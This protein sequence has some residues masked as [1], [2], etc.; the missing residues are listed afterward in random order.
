MTRQVSPFYSAP[1]TFGPMGTHMH[2][3]WSQSCKCRGPLLTRTTLFYFHLL[4]AGLESRPV[5]FRQAFAQELPKMP[6]NAQPHYALSTILKLFCP[7]FHWLHLFMPSLC[8]AK[9]SGAASCSGRSEQSR[10]SALC[11]LCGTDA[12]S[13]RACLVRWCVWLPGAFGEKGPTGGPIRIVFVRVPSTFTA[14]SFSSLAR[15]LCAAVAQVAVGL[16]KGRSLFL[17]HFQFCGI[18]RRQTS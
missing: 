1:S 7:A 6:S 14:N 9:Q 17:F 18:V 4:T 12:D 2:T 13:R 16:A 8:T 10:A 11:E 5:T 15:C 3:P